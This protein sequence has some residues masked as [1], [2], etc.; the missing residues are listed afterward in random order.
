[1]AALA[2]AAGAR[3]GGAAHE[4]ASVTHHSAATFKT[5]AALVGA[6]D[7]VIGGGAMARALAQARAEAS[8]DIAFSELES[9]IYQRACGRAA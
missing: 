1:M 4:T 9:Q 7:S 5:L 3:G 6:P 8:Y 2:A